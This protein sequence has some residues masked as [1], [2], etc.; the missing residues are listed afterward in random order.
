MILSRGNMFNYFLNRPI[1]LVL[2]VLVVLSVFSPILM[3]YVNKKSREGA[4]S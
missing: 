1:S 3:N 2:L 4:K